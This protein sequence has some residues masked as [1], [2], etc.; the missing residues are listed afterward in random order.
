M[1]VTPARWLCLC[2]PS[3]VV[4][5][6]GEDGNHKHV[7]ELWF[8]HRDQAENMGY[9][10]IT[11]CSMVFKEKLRHEVNTYFLFK[12]IFLKISAGCGCRWESLVFTRHKTCNLA[13]HACTT[14]HDRI[15]VTFHLCFKSCPAAEQ[16]LLDFCHVGLSSPTAFWCGF[17]ASA[18]VYS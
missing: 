8:T 12:Y 10:F 6:F 13:L 14:F 11:K 1:Y 9:L 15:P 18:L 3:V 2:K 5:L 16:K 17:S 4:K 7:S